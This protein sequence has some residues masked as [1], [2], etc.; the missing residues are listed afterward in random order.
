MKYLFLIIFSFFTMASFQETPERVSIASYYHDKHNSRKTANGEI[1][2]NSKIT[3]AHK[4]LPFGTKILVTNISNGK[5]VEVRI[6]DRGPFI[7]GREVDLSKA[8][9]SK[10]APLTQG[11]VK[12]KYKVIE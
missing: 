3:A 10:I 7:Q 1:F 4:K 2:Y 9:F 11:V 6:N 8:A 5:S 12:I